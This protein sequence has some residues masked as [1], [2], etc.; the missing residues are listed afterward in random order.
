MPSCSEAMGSRMPTTTCAPPPPRAC[1]HDPSLP[2]WLFDDRMLTIAYKASACKLCSSW[3]HHYV[4][5]IIQHDVSLPRAE[6]TRRTHFQVDLVAQRSSLTQ[7]N[8]V[9]H[10]EVTCHRPY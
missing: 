6:A 8:D 3:V 4:E 9:L 10:T 7:N 1:M 2:S 5:G